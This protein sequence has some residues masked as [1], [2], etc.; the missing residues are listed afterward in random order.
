VRR[1]KYSDFHIDPGN[2]GGAIA[3]PSSPFKNTPI[4]PIIFLCP[5]CRKEFANLELMREHRV[6]LH[7]LKRPY[8]L[9]SGKPCRQEEVVYRPLKKD[10]LIFEDTLSASLDGIKY[11]STEVLKQKIIAKQTGRR[12]IEL[13]YQEYSV[14][15][16]LVFDIILECDLNLVEECFYSTCKS[17]KL[18][19]SHLKIFY[20]KI[21]EKGLHGN[22]Y[23]GGLGCYLTGILAKDR[24][25][26]IGVPFEGFPKKF[27]ESEDKLININ[28]PL[29]QIIIFLI[30]LS[31]NYFTLP[32]SLIDT[33]IM[34]FATKFMQNWEFTDIPQCRIE[35]WLKIP[36]DLVTKQ[37]IAFC[38]Q[39]DTYRKQAL[40]ELEQ[41][42][43]HDRIEKNDRSKLVFLLM[44]YYVQSKD[45]TNADRLFKTI[46]YNPVFGETAKKIMDLKK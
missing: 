34:H 12:K 18:T 32:I 42:L 36:T 43:N 33:P 11:E 5:V 31:R 45:F 26:D 29:A 37:L 28:R 35:S 8:L 13:F 24:N 1:N 27:G 40:A 20:K 46:K 21:K 39:G 4:K 6:Q 9:I 22:A 14:T 17:E 10:S 2:S 25:P 38:L 41:W 15:I 19:A 44:V 23:A 3:I 30:K 16:Y 7:P